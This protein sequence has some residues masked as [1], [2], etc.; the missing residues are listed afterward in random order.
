[1][2]KISKKSIELKIKE[3]LQ[4]VVDILDD[5]P[6]ESERIKF[7]LKDNADRLIY[8]L[9]IK[10][11]KY[12]GP[13]YDNYQSN[14]WSSIIILLSNWCMEV[15]RKASKDKKIIAKELELFANKDTI[16][17]ISLHILR[18]I[19]SSELLDNMNADDKH[20]IVTLIDNMPKAYDVIKENIGNIINTMKNI[21]DTCVTCCTGRCSKDKVLVVLKDL[22]E[23]SGTVCIALN[24]IKDVLVEIYHDVD[25]SDKVEIE[26]DG[27]EDH[28]E[29]GEEILK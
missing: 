21:D 22:S 12:E 7:H 28:K 23:K 29:N 24:K 5:I 11:D 27:E 4:I 10:D 26:V 20:K 1:M 18:G 25:N 6:V 2:I 16:A 19:F 3:K 8:L 13:L 14:E 17:N 9:W 15:Y